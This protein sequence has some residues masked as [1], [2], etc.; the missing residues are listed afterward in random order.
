[1][2]QAMTEG[3]TIPQSRL[4]P[5]QPPLHKGAFGCGGINGH[6]KPPYPPR[7]AADAARADVGIGPYT[8]HSIFRPNRRGGYQPPAWPRCRRAFAERMGPSLP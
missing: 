5:C 6:I 2:A 8:S 7:K 3:L 4:T 1:M